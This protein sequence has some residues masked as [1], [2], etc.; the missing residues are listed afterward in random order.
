MVTITAQTAMHPTN[1][2]SCVV[3][4]VRHGFCAKASLSLN[5]LWIKHRIFYAQNLGMRITQENCQHFFT[6]CPA[7]LKVSYIYGPNKLIRNKRFCFI[8]WQRNNNW[9]SSLSIISFF[10]LELIIPEIFFNI[11]GT[12]LFFCS[13]YCANFVSKR[14]LNS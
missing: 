5:Y 13:K 11:L 9:I 4:G 10:Y 2:S 7:R 1:L 8:P 12:C 6:T 3:S 14:H